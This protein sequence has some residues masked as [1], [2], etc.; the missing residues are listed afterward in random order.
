[1]Y[2]EFES[3]GLALTDPESRAKTIQ[4][5]EN[6]LTVGEA[7][8]MSRDV[9]HEELPTIDEDWTKQPF[10]LV[11]MG[12]QVEGANPDGTDPNNPDAPA[13]E[14]DAKG[15][16]DPKANK[17]G[18][19]KPAKKSALEQ[20]A[21]LIEVRSQ[22]AAAEGAAAAEAFRAVTRK[23]AEGEDETVVYLP[24]ELMR[25]LVLTE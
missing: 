16:V 7:R 3:N 1:V 18:K 11:L 17:K 6:V 8:K 9:F 19:A 10:K 2:H 20:A 21:D 24:P 4:M 5:L 13:P 14:K 22:L 12:K 25:E 15:G 23:N